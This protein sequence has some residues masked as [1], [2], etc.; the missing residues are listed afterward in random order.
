[1]V[2]FT[3]IFLGSKSWGY[4]SVIKRHKK[5]PKMIIKI[6]KRDLLIASVFLIFAILIPLIYAQTG[7]NVVRRAGFKVDLVI[8]NR[9]PSINVSNVTGG[10]SSFSVDPI[11]ASNA[12]VLISFNVTDADGASNINASTAVVNFTLG[13]N[14][15]QYYV[16]QSFVAS[17]EF[18][19]CF[20]HSPSSTVVV[21]NCTVVLPYYANASASWVANISVKDISGGVGRNDTL[22]FTYNFVS[23][24]ALPYAFVNFSNVN[25]GQQNVLAYPHLLINNTGNEDFEMVN[26]TAAALV[27]T[28]TTTENIA[29]T[30]FAVNLTNS[31]A[32]LGLAFPSDGNVNLRDTATGN[33]VSFLHGHTSAFAPNA[34]KGNISA[35]IWVD[36]PSSGLTPQLYNATWNATA[37][38]N[39]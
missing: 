33:N 4:S 20:N 39:P 23:A 30:N 21:I 13:G 9:N 1:M 32:S 12:I 18:G 37:I 8:S 10:A 3:L 15:G 11:S 26:M 27:G 6:K 31:S 35:F 34:D 25:L 14:A 29:V 16:N 2:G 28:T 22:R 24:L 17:S 38:N 36:V 19:T 7:G 5:Y